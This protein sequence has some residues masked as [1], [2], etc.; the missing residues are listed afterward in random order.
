[1]K[2]IAFITL[3]SLIAIS[4]K[5]DTKETEPNSETAEVDKEITETKVS[6]TTLTENGIGITPI[7]HASLILNWDN[8]VMY[9]DPVGGAEAY[10]DQK[11]PDVILITDIHGDH[12][13]KR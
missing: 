8:T 3:L 7:S 1:M 9:V 5:T 2:K 12:L 11:Q 6:T 13:L 10:K 4:C